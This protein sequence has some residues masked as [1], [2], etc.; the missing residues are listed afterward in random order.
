MQA[1]VLKG[2]ALSYV[3]AKKK[4]NGYEKE[5]SGKQFIRRFPTLIS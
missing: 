2:P 4:E 1:Y 3:Q 5:V